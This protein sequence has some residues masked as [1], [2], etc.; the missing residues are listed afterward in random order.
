MLEFSEKDLLRGKVVSPDWYRVQLDSY[1]EKLAASGQSTNMNL[2]G[3]IIKNSSNGDLTFAGVPVTL[4]FNTKAPGFAIGFLQLFGIEPE[5]GKRY[6]LS[7]FVGKELD[8]FVENDMYEGRMVNRTNH[9]YRAA[10]D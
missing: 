9:K 10:R 6:D 3:T 2:E 1:E 8:V 7:A 4:R 5:K